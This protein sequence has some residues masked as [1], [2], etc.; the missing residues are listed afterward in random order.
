MQKRQ[1]DNYDMF[2]AVEN[3]F[4]DNPLLWNTNVPITATKTLLSSKID[5]MAAQVALQLV[6]PTG[7]TDEK[8]KIRTSLEDQTLLISGNTSGYAQ[9]V[10]KSELYKRV[11]YT[12]TDIARFRDAE[13]I[14]VCTTLAADATTELANLAPYGITAAVLTTYST[15][16]AAFGAIMK[17]PAGAIAKRKEATEKIED[18]IVEIVDIL[19][20]RMDNLIGM[21]NATQPSFVGIYK[22]LR[23]VNSTGSNQLSLTIT[24]L[25]AVSNEPIANV[26]LEL[27]GEGITRVSSERGYNTITNLVAGSHQIKAMHPN[28]KPK[29][30]TFTVVTGET[31]ELVL[32]LEAV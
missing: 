2:L 14:G 29:T 26:N 17:N 19:D 28:Y 27:V 3:H 5:A 8:E 23:A 24:T 16:V 25:N 21:L 31:T 22:N 20:T 11:F 18:F 10:G 9:I 30:A 15:T 1:I 4:D 13:F 6:N 7:I 32:L 12:K